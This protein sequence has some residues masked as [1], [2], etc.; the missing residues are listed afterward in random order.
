MPL[1]LLLNMLLWETDECGGVTEGMTV[2]SRVG[3]AR[4]PYNCHDA[5]K[6]PADAVLGEWGFLEYATENCWTIIE[7]VHAS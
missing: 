5:A 4:Q 2:M 7:S 3:V 1:L 6:G